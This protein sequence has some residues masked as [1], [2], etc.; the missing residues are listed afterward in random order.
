MVIDILIALL[1]AAGV[2]LLAMGLF[3]LRFR[4][5]LFSRIRTN[6][7]LCFFLLTFALYLFALLGISVWSASI[8][9]LLSL[10]GVFLLTRNAIGKLLKTD[11]QKSPQE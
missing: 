6:V 1:V 4:N 2:A 10:L 3:H 9:P 7:G 11:H 8:I 5:T